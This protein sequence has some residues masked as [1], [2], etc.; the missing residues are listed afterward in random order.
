MGKKTIVPVIALVMSLGGL[1]L[2]EGAPQDKQATT[3]AAATEKAPVVRVKTSLLDG[4]VASVDSAAKRIVIKKGKGNITIDVT[5]KT[6]ITK[7]KKDIT[8]ADIAAG[9]KVIVAFKKEGDKRRATT[10]KVKVP[11]TEKNEA[12][13]AENK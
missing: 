9:D 2:A 11:K 4:E 7:A 10:I 3:P 13:P 12:K 6:N 8:I 5:D 1:L